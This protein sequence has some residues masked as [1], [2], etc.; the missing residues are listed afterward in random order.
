MSGFSVSAIGSGSRPSFLIFWPARVTG[1]KS[2]TAA[3]ITIASACGA[4]ASIAACMSRAETVRMTFAPT[5]SGSSTLA[6][7]TVT[8]APRATADRANA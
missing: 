8:A 3:V 6:A 7:T 2:A 1:R 4:S 5:G